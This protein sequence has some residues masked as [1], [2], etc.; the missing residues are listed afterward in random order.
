MMQRVLIS[1]VMGLFFLSSC[2]N[3]PSKAEEE[4]RSNLKIVLEGHDQL[5]KEMSTMATL[6]Q[7]LEAQKKQTTDTVSI[8][9]AENRLKGAHEAMFEWMHAFSGDFEDLHLNEEE[10]LTDE[11]Y[12][13]RLRKLKLHQ[14]RLTRLDAEFKAGITAGKKV[15]EHK[16]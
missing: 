7:Q 6:I 2:T 10:K 14:E 9:K 8:N 11:Q 16:D 12:K 15:L 5:M 1:L 13:E 3:T 4:Y